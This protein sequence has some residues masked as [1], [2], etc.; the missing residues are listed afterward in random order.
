MPFIVFALLGLAVC[1]F[2]RALFNA[3]RRAVIVGLGVA[4][5]GAVI[6]GALFDHIARTGARVLGITDALVAAVT[7]AVV[8]LA[9]YH[10]MLG[11]TRHRRHRAS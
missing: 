6:S 10:A 2:T 1:R 4:V 9:A 3:T 5:I 8:L 11:Y 7:G